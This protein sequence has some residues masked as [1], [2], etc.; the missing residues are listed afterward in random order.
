MRLFMEEIFGVEFPET[1]LSKVF[2]I[3]EDV[4]AV[5]GCREYFIQVGKLK[6]D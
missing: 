6:F 5:L 2:G 1:S 3:S 4:E